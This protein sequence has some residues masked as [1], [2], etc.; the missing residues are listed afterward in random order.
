MLECI[1][2]IAAPLQE[3]V[4]VRSRILVVD[5]QPLNIKVA[6]QILQP[7]YDVYMAT[8]AAEAM[9]FCTKEKPDL[10]LLDVFMPE[11]SGLELCKQLK[12]KEETKDIPVIFV[13]GSPD[14]EQEHQCWVAGG[15]DF[16]GKPF[17]PMTLTHRVKAQLALKQQADQ[18]RQLAYVDELTGLPNRRALSRLFE[19]EW[20]RATREKTWLGILM[21]DVDHFKRYNDTLGHQAG[22]ECLRRV[23]QAIGVICRRS[24][25]VAARYGGEE[26]CCLLPGSNQQALESIGATIVRMVASLAIPHQTELGKSV[27]VSIGGASVIPQ[28][29]MSASELLERADRQLYNAKHTGRNKT[30]IEF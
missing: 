6:Y 17:S 4:N 23:S 18:L 7:D 2:R 20:R 26:I 28:I 24:H 12:A 21:I 14:S 25:D 10:V 30:C 19:L 8:N 3:T 5:D 15:V 27:S 29:D 16:V 22:D 11:T 1:S 13:T 9:N